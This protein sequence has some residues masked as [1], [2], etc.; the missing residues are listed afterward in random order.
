M[1]YAVMAIPPF[2]MKDI[3]IYKTNSSVQKFRDKY[4]TCFLSKLMGLS[5]YGKYQPYIKKRPGINPDLS[6]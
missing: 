5:E 3:L 4:Q 1:Q 2:E 6:L